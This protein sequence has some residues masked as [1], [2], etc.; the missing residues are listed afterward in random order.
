[1]AAYFVDS[2]QGVGGLGDGSSWANAYLTIAL[3]IA[4]P[5][6]AGDT[7]WV[8]DD[9]N[10]STAGAVTWTFPGTNASPNFIY[11][12]DHTKASPGSG[13]L[14]TTG[15]CATTGANSLT[16]NGSAY[17]Y[18]VQLTAGS[19]GTPS[20]SLAQTAGNWLEFDTCVLANGSASATTAAINPAANV[21][22]NNT[23]LKFSAAGAGYRLQGRTVWKN[24]ANALSGTVP[25]ALFG[26]AVSGALFV[27]EGIDLGAMGSGKTIVSAGGVLASV[28]LKD[29]KLGASVTVAGTPTIPEAAIYVVRSDSS[30]TNYVEQ[31][32]KYTGTQV[33]ETTIVRTG[34]ATDGTTPKSRKITTTANSKWV[35]PFESN[36]I[37][38]WNPTTA[39]N[40]TVTIH[41]TWNQ[42]AVPNNDDVWIDVEYLGSSASPLGSFA[43][44]T[45][46]N[47]LATGVALTADSASVW[48]GGGSGAGWS[49]FTISVTLLS[50]QPAQVGT[51]YITPKAAKASSTFYIDPLI[52]LS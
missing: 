8:G 22:L 18:G 30:G 38:I 41:G 7:L 26:S 20:L 35:L 13:D 43:T 31:V 5:I 33:D 4:R 12:V 2:V 17:F 27:L 24:T 23:Q 16:V 15:A 40:V 45:K 48:G 19:S 25:T 34:G 37:A 50:P 28:F 49:P 47:N 3:A 44:T 11:C 6:A 42:N 21:V 29:C 52:T 1:M 14:K 32:Y 9:H 46:A 36:P 39:K 10:E 51:F